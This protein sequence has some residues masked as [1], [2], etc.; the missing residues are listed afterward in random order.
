[1]ILSVTVEPYGGVQSIIVKTTNGQYTASEQN[2]IG[3]NSVCYVVKSGDEIHVYDERCQFKYRRTI[4]HPP[5]V[6][7]TGIIITEQ[8]GYPFEID[9]FTGTRLREI[10]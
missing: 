4:N 1:M 3:F 9:P 8:N 6:T 7:G 2:V 10:Y 5:V